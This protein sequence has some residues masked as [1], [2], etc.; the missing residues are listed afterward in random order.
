MSDV[1][2]TVEG[3]IEGAV[4][5]VEGLFAKGEAAASAEVADVKAAAAR[6][7]ESLIVEFDALVADVRKLEAHLG[8]GPKA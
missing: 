3:A 8:F 6:T 4:Q 5:K 2:A 7:F 1:I